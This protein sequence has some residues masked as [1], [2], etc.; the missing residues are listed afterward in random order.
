MSKMNVGK[1]IDVKFHLLVAR[2][3]AGEAGCEVVKQGLQWMLIGIPCCTRIPSGI[4]YDYCIL[5][6][7]RIQMT[8][9]DI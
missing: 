9:G 3:V 1:S 5:S 8:A 6:L 4:H 2:G 7:R